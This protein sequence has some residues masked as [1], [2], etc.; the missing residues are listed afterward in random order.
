MMVSFSLTSAENQSLCQLI[1]A[2]K[3][4]QGFAKST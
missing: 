3:M 2:A 1:T 4:A